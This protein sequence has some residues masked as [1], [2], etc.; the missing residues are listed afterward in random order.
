MVSQTGGGLWV[1]IISQLNC[2][3][4]LASP[5]QRMARFLSEPPN[6]SFPHPLQSAL[7]RRGVE[8]VPEA[9]LAAKLQ[10]Q[11]GNRLA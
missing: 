7:I 5:Q 9:E 6:M 2:I 1:L 8:N 3:N 4:S 11:T 10:C